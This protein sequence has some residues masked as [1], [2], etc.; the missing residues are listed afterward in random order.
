MMKNSTHLYT[1]ILCLLAAFLLIPCNTSQAHF[2]GTNH[3]HPPTLS[4]TLCPGDCLTE[5]KHVDLEGTPERL[6]LIFSIDL[7]G[8]MGSILDAVKSNAVTIM[9][10]VRTIIPDSYFAN[11]SFMDYPSSYTSCGYSAGYGNPAAGD[12]PYSLDNPLT[13]DIILVSNTLNAYVLGDGL[14]L[15]E[16]Y[17][18]V[19]YEAYSDPLIGWRTGSKRILLN[20]GDSIPHDCDVLSCIPIPGNTMGSDPGRNGIA[21][22]MDDLPLLS[23]VN[24]MTTNNIT[25]LKVYRDDPLGINS[26]LW[27]CLAA[28][29]GGAAFD[30]DSV[31]ISDIS[32]E[33]VKLVRDSVLKISRLTLITTP[34]YE[35]WLTSVIPPEYTGIT[36]S[37][38]QRF[39]FDIQICVPLGTPPGTYNFEVM[40]EGDGAIYARQSVSIEVCALTNTPTLT[41]TH[42][43]TSL[44][45]LTPTA[46]T[47][48]T[49]TST[50]TRTN[51]PTFTP[52]AIPTSTPTFSPTHTP[53]STPTLTPTP[54]PPPT[55]YCCWQPAENALEPLNSA[56]RDWH[57]SIGSDNVTLFF[58]SVRPGGFGFSDI[59]VSQRIGPAVSDWSVPA[60]L[61]PN[62]NTSVFES[63]PTTTGDMQTLYFMG[64]N[65]SNNTYDIY[66]SQFNSKTSTWAP[67]KIANDP[68]SSP[69]YPDRHPC[70][71]KDGRK[72]YFDS[73]RPSGAGSFD[74][75]EATSF[76]G[77]WIDAKPLPVPVNS[78]AYDAAPCVWE[79]PGKRE[80]YYETERGGTSELF[81]SEWDTIAEMWLSPKRMCLAFIQSLHP[82]IN[83]AGKEMFYHSSGKIGNYDI[84]IA[85]C[86]PTPTPTGTW[87]S[88]TPTDT[89]PLPA[90]I[91]ALDNGMVSVLGLC[92]CMIL[93]IS[94][95]GTRRKSG[96]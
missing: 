80:L 64:Y 8:S 67:R 35:S 3:M 49:S 95:Q 36:L 71:M 10:N 40:A 45:S 15:P 32:D 74:I 78:A 75:W 47:T 17:T 12:Y 33:I 58:A 60:N 31:P 96:G 1:A 94:M 84:F 93:I 72:I 20:F 90:A 88:P 51:V 54:T 55:I 25:L 34:G 24:I 2:D 89:I 59:Y 22:D 66:Y 16:S 7:T 50:A 6:D 92:L 41:A 46:T 62:I 44:F 79:G 86:E 38:A 21:G 73:E 42:S 11:V 87:F 43:P 91:P 68:V 63:A 70:I 83:S 19:F 37:S 48:Q 57:P 13:S 81:V 18:R 39:T 61:G 69:L 53:T 5:T 14:D 26:L 77:K 30:F 76:R 27:T 65:T 9:T 82:S 28:L 85:S 52:T 4:A 29:N 23:I 56:Y